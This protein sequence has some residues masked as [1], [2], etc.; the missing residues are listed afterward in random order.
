[1]KKTILLFV[2]A[3]TLA[4]TACKNDSKTEGAKGADST[5]TTEAKPAPKGKY[6]L[7]SGIV[8]MKSQVMGMEQKQV[9][10]FDE[11][12]A[13][14]CVEVTASMFGQK[15]H[16]LN[17]NKDG[18]AYSI[19]MVKKI[20]TKI[21]IPTDA[22]LNFNDLG[23]GIAKEMN[24]KK[25]GTETV[26]GKTCDKYTI[27]YKKQQMKGYY[28]VWNGIALKTELTVMGMKTLVEV[29]KIDEN[30]AVPADKFEIPKGIKI[31]DMPNMP[32]M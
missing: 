21:K 31:Q 25:T 11:Y 10:F 18:Y 8:E 4:F 28:L 9:L 3:T 7:K 12:G 6:S 17:I 27:D 16:N 22:A 30:A 20:G 26:L 1:M 14:E 13:K 29:T 5:K 23:K 2:A 24:I 32:K 19:D 15:A